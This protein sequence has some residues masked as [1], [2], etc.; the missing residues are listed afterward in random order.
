[1]FRL[2]I[3]ALFLCSGMTGLIYQ[4]VWAKQLSVVF[5]V[6]LLAVST[7]LACFFGGLALGSFLGG[8]WV[9]RYKNGFKWYGIA[10]ALIGLYALIFPLLLGLNN[11]VYV[12]LAE[13]LVKGPLGLNLL[14]FVLSAVILIIPTTLMGATLPLLSRTVALIDRKGRFAFDVGG[15]YAVNT[16]GAIAGAVLAAFFLIPSFGMR[17]ILLSTGAFNIGL[18]VLA[19]ILSARVVRTESQG[20]AAAES[21]EAPGKEEKVPGYFLKLLVIAF[22]ISGFTGLAYEVVWTRILG[23]IL[24]GTV[25]AFAAV[26]AVFLFGIAAGSFAFSAFLDRIRS[27]GAVIWIF[28]A[29]EALIGLG[30]IGLITLYDKLP[31]FGFYDRIST[32]PDWGEFIYL[33]FFTS[34]IT[35]LIPAFLFGATFPLVCRIYGKGNAAIGTRIGN[36]YSLNTVGGIAGSFAGGFILIPLIGMQNALVLMGMTNIALGAAFMLLNPF[37]KK[38]V[39]LASAAAIGVFAALALLTLPANM[40]LTIHKTFLVGNERIAFYREGAAATVMIAERPWLASFNKRLWVNGNRATASF[41]EGLRINRFQGV[42]PMALHPEPKDVLVICFGSGTTFGTLSRFPVNMV[43]N[44]EIAPTV[45]EAAGFFKSEN[46]DVLHNPKARINYDDGRSFLMATARK[47]D[48][49]TEEPMHPSLAGVVNLYTKEY[50]ELAKAH[51]KEG[52]IMSQWIP[53]YNLSIDDVKTMVRTFQS[54]FPHTTIWIVNSDIFMIGAPENKNIDY[55]RVVER[56]GMPGVDRLLLDIDLRDPGEFLNTFLMNEDAVR[57]Y[58]GDS[59]VMSDDMPSVEFT[60]PRSLNINTVSPNIAELLRFREPVVAY[61]DVP[62]AGNPE[63]VKRELLVKFD[64]GRLNLIGRAYFAD[65]NVEKAREYFRAAVQ[66]NPGDL[67]SMRYL[68]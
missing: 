4:V 5:G 47:F 65:N 3:F 50:Y 35:L 58:A 41:Y 25:Y 60:G 8:R 15:L 63:K 13:T 16:V 59:P 11:S 51:L 6:T 1:M 39:R 53:L 45:V 42:L 29:V 48:V 21:A 57:R 24:T 38:A 12:M 32:T 28:A 26:L 43:D 14:K 10:E 36:I 23:F 33:N 37:H 30:S 56:L 19:F 2:L 20:E 31:S 18:G 67:N 27:R 55:G 61:L 64:G 49:I 44:V 66:A 40:P 17:N 54:V 62:K 46:A 9:D 68:R 7:V 52:G 22:G 34:F